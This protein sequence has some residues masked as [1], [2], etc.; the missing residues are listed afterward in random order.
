MAGAD[1][2]IHYLE[3]LSPTASLPRNPEPTTAW[4]S[5]KGIDPGYVMVMQPYLKS[6]KTRH[7]TLHKSPFAST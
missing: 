2:F 4:L 7:A 1:V 5:H 3:P 6:Q